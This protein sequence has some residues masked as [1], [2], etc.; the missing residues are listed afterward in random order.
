MLKP[1]FL[2]K[3]AKFAHSCPDFE[4]SLLIAGGFDAMFCI[5]TVHGIDF[6][7]RTYKVPAQCTCAGWTS[8]TTATAAL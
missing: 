4:W 7:Y 2:S 1:S 8:A 6:L 5:M 3:V